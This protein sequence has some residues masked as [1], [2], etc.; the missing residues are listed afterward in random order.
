V[1]S[2]VVHHAYHDDDTPEDFAAIADMICLGFFFL[3][4]PGEHTLTTDNTPFKLED[5]TLYRGGTQYTYEQC[6]PVEFDNAT[7]VTLTFT[8]Q[9]NGVKNEIIRNGMTGDP[10]VCPVRAA[11]RRLHYHK[12]HNSPPNTDLC[13]YYDDGK[14]RHVIS[15]HIT[16]A[17]RAGL[18]MVLAQGIPLNIKPSDI[19][20]RSLRSGGATAMLCA[21]IDKDLTQLQGR[22]KS[23]AMIRYLHISAAPIVDKFAR[24]MFKAGNF[25]FFPQLQQHYQG[26]AFT[27]D[28]PDPVD[29]RVNTAPPNLPNDDPALVIQTPP[30]S[31]SEPESHSD[32]TSPSSAAAARPRRAVQRTT[33][34][35]STRTNPSHSSSSRSDSFTTTHDPRDTTWHHSDSESAS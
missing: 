34:L 12:L 28:D 4:R 24:K 2:A 5:V 19:D 27:Y 20:A 25:S 32:S 1:V 18:K 14:P 26:Y 7:S 21:K 23:D 9:K 3:C 29:L 22:W 17:L 13:S 16:Q 33:L 30:S 6:H 15:R 35:P 8:T 10:F 11:A 31:D